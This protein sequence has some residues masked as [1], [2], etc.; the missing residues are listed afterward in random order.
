MWSLFKFCATLDPRTSRRWT[1]EEVLRVAESVQGRTFEDWLLNNT[2]VVHSARALS[3][4]PGFIQRWYVPE[5]TKVQ[6]LYLRP[7]LGTEVLPFSDLD[8]WLDHVG[9]PAM[10]ENQSHAAPR[11]LPLTSAIEEHLERY[12]HMGCELGLSLD[13][14]A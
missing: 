9:L 3:K 14:V 5:T 6:F 4:P 2:G 7:D 8:G 10:H 13:E 12:F 11:C 1:Q